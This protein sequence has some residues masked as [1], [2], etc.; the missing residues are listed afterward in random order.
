MGKYDNLGRYLTSLLENK[1]ILSMTEIV[2]IL[3]FPLP[4]SSVKYRP[5]WANDRTHVQALDGWMKF[6]WMVETI[7]FTEKTVTFSKKTNATLQ[8]R[9]NSFSFEPGKMNPSRFEEMARVVMSNHF[10]QELSPR[11]LQGFPKLFDLVSSDGTIIGDAK[12]LTMVGGT[13]IPPAKFATIAEY[14]WLLEKI[15]CKKKFLVFGNDKRVPE[16]WLKRYGN[17]V[18]DVEFYFIGIN[19]QKL[20]KLDRG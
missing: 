13:S 17:L 10:Q 2:D 8:E 7:D 16:E 14:V 11:K 12:Y 6:G 1:I 4:D 20:E 3:G 5:W 19:T 18:T 9:S 15:P